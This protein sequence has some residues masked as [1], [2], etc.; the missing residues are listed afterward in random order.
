MSKTIK[1][2]F[3]DEI[4]QEDKDLEKKY[5]IYSYEFQF[6]RNLDIIM[7]AYT[8]NMSQLN[9]DYLRGIAARLGHEGEDLRFAIDLNDE[10]RELTLK[11]VYIPKAEKPAPPLDK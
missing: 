8:A 10:K 6:L 5:T 2:Q 1:Q 4:P 3:K 9:D 11:R 7:R